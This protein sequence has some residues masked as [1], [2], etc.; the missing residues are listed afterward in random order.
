M[1]D[2]VNELVP[3]DT[4]EFLEVLGIVFLAGVVVGVLAGAGWGLVE[5]ARAFG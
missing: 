2:D 3:L 5:L 1:D 4:A